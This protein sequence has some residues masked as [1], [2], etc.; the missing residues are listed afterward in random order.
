MARNKFLEDLVKESSEEMDMY[1]AIDLVMGDLEKV[2]ERPELGIAE[3]IVGNIM[4]GAKVAPLATLLGTAGVIHAALS[5]PERDPVTGEPESKLGNMLAEGI[6]GALIGRGI[7]HAGNIAR[8]LEGP[9]GAYLRRSQ[10]RVLRGKEPSLSRAQSYKSILKGRQ[11]ALKVR[12]NK[13]SMSKKAPK[14]KKVEENLDTN[15]SPEDLASTLGNL[16]PS[17]E[18]RASSSNVVKDLSESLLSQGKSLAGHIDEI[19]PAGLAMVGGAANAIRKVIFPDKDNSGQEDDPIESAVKGA[20]YGGLTGLAVGHGVRAFKPSIEGGKPWGT[21]A[22]E[23]AKNI[24]E[25]LRGVFEE[26]PKKE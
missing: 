17:N 15:L 20:I 7:S 11:Q 25:G 16:P 18:K 1:E 4:H 23:V 12:A 13:Q 6:G 24:R 2:A 19:G 22:G 5:D 21:Q 9:T 14:L 8:G 26:A 3:N 10:L